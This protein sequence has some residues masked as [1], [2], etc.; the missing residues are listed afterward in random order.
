MKTLSTREKQ[1][2]VLWVVAVV[3]MAAVYYW[4]EGGLLRPAQDMMLKEKMVNKLR[5]MAA[6][7]PGRE[8]AVKKLT[9]ELA[10]REKG[11]LNADTAPQAQALLLQIVRRVAAQQP[12]LVF[13]G[14][15][16]GAPKPLGDSYG[17]VTTAVSFDGTIEQIVNLLSDLANQE[18]LISVTELQLGQA[19]GKSKQL[20]VRLTVAGVVPRKLVPEKKGGAAL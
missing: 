12:G 8:E 9:T 10:R 6:A 20:P 15:E 4:P 14:I 17:E 5:R 19:N 2:L 16:F 1:A 7:Q 13:K 3:V 11:I 18:E